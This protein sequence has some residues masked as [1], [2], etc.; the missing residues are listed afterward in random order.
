M[1]IYIV[2]TQ[3]MLCVVLMDQK[4]AEGWTPAGAVFP[5]QNVLPAEEI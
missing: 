5:K 4:A 3:S 1:Y 2:P